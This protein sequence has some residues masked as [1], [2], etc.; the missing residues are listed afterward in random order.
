MVSIPRSK[1]K[2]T[3][4]PVPIRG[5]E[6][7]AEEVEGPEGLRVEM[8]ILTWNVRGFNDPRE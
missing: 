2:S 8:T 1:R 7:R 5:R 6:A 4:E 3:I